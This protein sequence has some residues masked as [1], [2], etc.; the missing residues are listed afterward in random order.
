MLVVRRPKLSLWDKL[1]LGAVFKGMWITLKHA[2]GNI[3]HQERIL[4]YEYPEMK[5][6]I[7]ENYR[8]EHRLMRRPDETPR[9]TACMLCATACPA[10]CIEIVAAEHPDPRVEKYPAVYNINLL[11]C[12]YCSLCVEACPCDA[13]RMDTMKIE[14]AGYTR[15]HFIVDKEYLLKNHPEGKSPYSIALY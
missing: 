5:K 3:F 2:V 6:P 8:A 7:P 15:E 9:C 10:D 1:Y 11:R 14:Q 12:V 4:T 13:I